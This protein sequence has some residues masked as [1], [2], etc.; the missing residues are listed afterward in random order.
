LKERLKKFIAS[1]V[2]VDV[3]CMTAI[4][5]LAAVLRV[6]RWVN[7][8]HLDRDGVVYLN[9]MRF[10]LEGHSFAEMLKHFIFIWEYPVPL[11]LLRL[12]ALL[13]ADLE[14]GA[15]CMSIL[16]G[17]AW[18]V[19]MY[20]VMYS[21]FPCRYAAVY[22]GVIAGLQPM[23][24]K[25]SVS[26]LRD[27][28]CLFF[29]TLTVYMMV[30]ALRGG[31]KSR[32]YYAAAGFFAAAALLCRAEALE[33]PAALVLGTAAARIFLPKSGRERIDVRG[34]VLCFAS[35][36]ASLAVLGAL[37]GINW[38]ILYGFIRTVNGKIL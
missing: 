5:V 27:T 10:L 20:R 28:P 1:P 2:A 22:A 35:W 8:M 33:L 13:G 15:I 11:F 6:V 9:E 37:L 26:I 19:L 31:A 32:L 7:T 24:L 38:S 3:L 4:F 25:L 14:T 23:A 16:I 12:P 36:G 29:T 34:I 30:C 21:L 18:A 17:S